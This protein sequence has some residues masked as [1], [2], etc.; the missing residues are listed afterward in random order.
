MVDDRH[1]YDR[2]GAGSFDTLISDT[3]STYARPEHDGADHKCR[4]G[5]F[6]CLLCYL[7]RACLFVRS[8]PDAILRDGVW[9][10]CYGGMFL[11]REDIDSCLYC[12]VGI[13]LALSM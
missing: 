10:M 3:H 11:D 6:S 5:S 7:L 12:T 13:E 4:V 2:E 8:L 1:Q 9:N